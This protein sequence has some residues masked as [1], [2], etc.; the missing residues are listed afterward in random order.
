[1]STASVST[2][3]AQR[4]A[5]EHWSA[6]YFHI[7][8]AGEVEAC[9]DL[10]HAHAGISLL[11]IVESVK[12]K[13]LRLP[14][15]VRFTDILRHRVQALCEAFESAAKQYHYAGAHTAV[16]PI[17]VNQQF[18]IVDIIL[19]HRR[20]HTGLEAGSKPELLAVLSIAGTTSTTIICNGYKDNDYITLALIAQRLGHKVTI[21]IEKLSE[22]AR[23]VRI[24]KRMGVTPKLGVRVRLASIGKGKWQNTGGEKSKFGLTAPQIIDLLSKLQAENA[25]D[26][27]QC[28]HFHLGSQLSNLGDIQTGLTEAA[29][30]YA[31]LCASGA[32]INTID[33]GGGLAVDYEGSHSRSY[34]SMNYTLAEYANAVVSAFS[35]ICEKHSLTP[36]NIITES[37]RAMTAHHAV[38]ITNVIDIDSPSDAGKPSIANTAP[39]ILKAFDKD[40]TTCNTRNALE[41]YHSSVERMALAQTQFSAG[42]LSLAQRAQ[43]EQYYIAVLKQVRTLLNPE[44][45][46]HRDALMLLNEKLADKYF[47][48][49]SVFQS[50][51]DVWAI[52][53]VFPIMPIHRLHES[54]MQEAILQD[55]T[56][57]SDGH[58]EEYVVKQGLAKTLPVPQVT[59]DAPLYLGIFLVGAYQEILGDIHNLF[60]DTDSVHVS[61]DASGKLNLSLALQGDTVADVL[62]A[63]HFE[64]AKLV[65]S[66]EMQLHNSQ[67]PA[68][69]QQE[70]LETLTQALRGYTYFE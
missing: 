53:Q 41:K 25:L 27:L 18:R 35:S 60:G 39:D 38:L 54:V 3:A 17:K 22:V 14:V 6:G 66:F 52:S 61:R 48:N 29:Q 32:N 9:P 10:Q 20:A 58:I 65:E 64:E 23:I 63:V 69:E 43:A 49:L 70:I 16:Y 47:C 55:I 11:E 44:I 2:T 36:P 24:A 34:Y 50:L 45:H 13:G 1:M 51:P 33:V 30:F 37:G 42:Q 40:L 68:T 15:L 59:P 46:A 62:R 4:Y 19:N 8:A 7:N 5:L 56:C 57:D 26:C 28:L 31:E 67:L 12:A 21:I